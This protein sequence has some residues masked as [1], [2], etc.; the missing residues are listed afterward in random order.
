MA[1][2]DGV[3]VE[4]ALGLVTA[5][6]AAGGAGAQAVGGDD[7]VAIVWREGHGCESAE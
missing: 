5:H 3:G 7:E 4:V 1:Q 2:G 6:G